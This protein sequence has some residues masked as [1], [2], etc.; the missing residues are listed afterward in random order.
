MRKQAYVHAP[1]PAHPFVYLH[2][3]KQRTSPLRSLKSANNGLVEAPPRRI[4][5]H[6]RWRGLYAPLTRVSNA[7]LT[8]PNRLLTITQTIT[9]QR[10]HA[11]ATVSSRALAPFPELVFFFPVD[12]EPAPF[13]TFFRV[14]LFLAMISASGAPLAGR[15]RWWCFRAYR[16]F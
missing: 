11:I 3:V 16:F 5:R 13:S 15:C 8:S 12:F 6:E 14:G 1:P 2:N 10:F 4:D 9:H 7:F